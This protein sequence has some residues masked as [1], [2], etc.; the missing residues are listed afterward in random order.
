MNRGEIYLCDFGEPLGHE[1]A[2]R[3]PALIVSATEMTQFGLPIV[4]PITRT[5]RGY[6]THVELDGALPVTSYAQCE[7][8]RAVA[9]ER[10]LRH[11]GTVD[12]VDLI[13]VESVLRR[14]LVI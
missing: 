11:V 10:I 2:F 6:P 14:I 3:R 5:Q 12:T 7:Q 4:L 8:I 13:K 9:A 1:P